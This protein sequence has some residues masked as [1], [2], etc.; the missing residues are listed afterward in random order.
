MQSLLYEYWRLTGGK[1][2]DSNKILKR[3]KIQ[4]LG[5][6]EFAI[7][8][9]G[10]MVISGIGTYII[11]KR[12]NGLPK[13]SIVC[14]NAAMNQ[15]SKPPAVAWSRYSVLLGIGFNSF[16]IIAGIFLYLF[17]LPQIMPF[18]F[19]DLPLWVNWVGLVGFWLYYYSGIQVIKYNV[20]YLPLY[21]SIPKDYILVTGGPYRIVR[22]PM[23]I[24][25]IIGGFLFFFTSG[26][27]LQFFG[28]LLAILGLPIQTK[29]EE[30]AMLERFGNQYQDYMNRTGRF[31]PRLK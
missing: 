23:Y 27:W 20:N 11:R 3:L 10:G 17:D 21:K 7:G 15:E 13:G 1:F 29:G 16:V 4:M 31:F 6:I 28:V 9:I 26:F 24:L 18:L 22:H 25:K 8:L 30:K 12:K 2:L 5:K 19:V 14:D